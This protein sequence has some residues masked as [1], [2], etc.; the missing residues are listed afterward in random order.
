MLERGAR[1]LN[2]EMDW[3]ILGLRNIGSKDGTRES[4][5]PD[6]GGGLDLAWTAKRAPRRGCTARR[7]FWWTKP[8]LILI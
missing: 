4:R 7:Q 5:L 1:F 8:V 2:L 6:K 3:N